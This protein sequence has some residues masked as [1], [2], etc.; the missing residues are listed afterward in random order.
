MNKR[1][2][3]RDEFR[4]AVFQR[5]GHLCVFCGAPAQDA[6]HIIERRLWSDGGYYIDNGAS[7]CE[8]HHL[9]CERTDITPD[10]VRRR[11]GITI[12][13]LPEHLYAD[14]EYDKWGNIVLSSGRRL[15]GELFFDESVQKVLKQHLDE[16]SDI[17]K[18]PRTYHLPWSDNMHDDDRMMRSTA[19]FLGKRVIVTEKMDGENTTMYQDFIHARSLDSASNPTRSW[20]KNF[21]ATISHDIPS[22]WR[23]CGE[24]LWAKH[25]IKY[26]HLPSYFM[27]FS[28]WNDKNECLSWDETVEWFELLGITPVSVFY[29]GIYDEAAI[30]KLYTSEQWAS[31]EGYVIRI[32][33]NFTYGRFRESVGKYVR[34]N[35]IQTVQ[36]WLQ[37]SQQE[38]NVVKP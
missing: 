9:A 2:L 32:A 31:S 7:V 14:Q 37:D 29:D 10:E 35:H 5:D 16:F 6:H 3:T 20:V 11:C 26:E 18:Y 21:W 34:K 38:R 28:I 36:H 23:I 30:R 4:R 33:E 17:V 15:K 13:V 19:S 25:S 24:N 8:V 27:G 1:L 22:G 12:I